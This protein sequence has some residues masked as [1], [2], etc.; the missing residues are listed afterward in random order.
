MGPPVTLLPPLRGMDQPREVVRVSAWVRARAHV[1]AGTVRT[2]LWEE[3]WGRG[4]LFGDVPK[5]PA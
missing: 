2:S 1:G 4:G 5:D 3:A